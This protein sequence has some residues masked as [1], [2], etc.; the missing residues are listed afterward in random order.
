MLSLKSQEIEQLLNDFRETY[1][2]F[3]SKEL[4]NVRKKIG[5]RVK[6]VQEKINRV[7]IDAENFH[8]EITETSPTMDKYSL[9]IEEEVKA[10]FSQL[11]PPE[12]ITYQSV[13]DYI[14]EITKGLTKLDGVFKKYV[15]LLK[16]KKKYTKRVKDMDRDI[17]KLGNELLKLQSEL[18]SQYEPHR[19][20]ESVIELIKE[21]LE[22]KARVEQIE[23][24][25]KNREKD[26]LEQRKVVEELQKELEK[27]KSHE[28]LAK[29]EEANQEIHEMRKNLDLEF[30]EIKKGLKKLWKYLKKNRIEYN[31]EDQRL[32]EQFSSDPVG[33]LG[34]GHQR[35]LRGI[36]SLLEKH[37]SKLQLKKEKEEALKEALHAMVNEG[38]LDEL[39]QKAK[40]VWER[41]EKIRQQLAAMKLEET[42]KELERKLRDAQ[43]DLDRITEALEREKREQLEKI[44]QNWSKIK[45]I[46]S[47]IGASD[48]VPKTLDQVLS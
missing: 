38:K 26:V 46:A 16:D 15:P 34:T 24:E 48:L 29:L 7:L 12:S 31:K 8:E 42:E 47:S 30:S 33:T 5:S 36:F 17:K 25:L 28:L 9:K 22:R 40:Q 14:D 39:A 35:T 32:A 21:I 19:E 43:R 27:I 6:K 1:S 20:I 44:R 23:N 11:E 4:A 2:E 45:E 18:Q 13:K 10:T 37:S 3:I 41:R